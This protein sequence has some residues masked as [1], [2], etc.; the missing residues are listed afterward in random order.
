MRERNKLQKIFAGR[1]YGCSMLRFNYT[2]AACIIVLQLR[3]SS[4]VKR[5]WRKNA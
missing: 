3:V 5:L 1:I 4:A 2:C